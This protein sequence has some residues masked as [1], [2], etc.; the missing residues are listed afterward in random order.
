[1]RRPRYD[2]VGP[3]REKWPL[4]RCATPL[5]VGTIVRGTPDRGRKPGPG[6]A[7][8]GR[9]DSV[10]GNIET[11][12]PGETSPARTTRFPSGRSTTES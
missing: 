4:G 5:Q 9:R 8:W 3:A 1:M 10:D 7:L 11:S 2:T 6:V 12:H